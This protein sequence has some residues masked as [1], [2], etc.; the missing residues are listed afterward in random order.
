MKKN[1]VVFI[2]FVFVSCL[3]FG[4]IIKVQVEDIGR[5]EYEVNQI[6]K[7]TQE[8]VLEGFTYLPFNKALE[9]AKEHGTRCLQKLLDE[10][11]LAEISGIAKATRYWVEEGRMGWIF[12]FIISKPETLGG[13]PVELAERIE[14]VVFDSGV[15]LPFLNEVRVSGD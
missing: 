13:G 7:V 9:L 4:V 8:R 1:L 5:L 15:C 11:D 10:G 12:E 14:I 6:P 2:I 3:A